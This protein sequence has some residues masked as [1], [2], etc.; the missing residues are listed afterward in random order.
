MTRFKN[1]TLGGE[2]AISYK[3]GALAL[4]VLILTIPLTSKA[5]GSS[6]SFVQWTFA[7]VVGTIPAIAALFILDRV[8]WKNRRIRP[9]KNES[10]FLAGGLIGALKGVSTELSALFLLKIDNVDLYSITERTISSSSI[11]AI[12]IPLI[13][14]M[15]FSWSANLRIR[16]T[17][18]N[19]LAGIDNLLESLGDKTVELEFLEITRD[20]ISK[21]KDEFISEFLLTSNKNKADIAY[22]LNSIA[23]ELIRP[24]SHSAN[25]ILKRSIIKDHT[26]I[27]SIHRFPASVNLGIPWLI[28]LFISSSARIQLQIRGILGGIVMLVFS[29]FIFWVCINLFVWACSRGESS[30]QKVFGNFVFAIFLNSTLSWAVSE[31]LFSDYK[32]NYLVNV[33]WCGIIVVAVGIGTLF[34]TY[35]L[36]ELDRLEVEYS[37]KYQKLLRLE[38]GRTRITASLARYLHGT[39]QTRLIASAYRIRNLSSISDDSELEKELR[40]VLSHFDLPR[41][42]TL[43]VPNKSSTQ[44]F[45]EIVELW[46][47]FMDIKYQGIALQTVPTKTMSKICEF[48]NEALSNSFRHGKA[49]AIQITLLETSKEITI[50]IQ[51]NGQIVTDIKPSLGMETF[52]WVSTHWK[53]EHLSNGT[54]VTGIFH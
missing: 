43:E 14:L 25:Q 12:S 52:N 11:G 46:K 29:T 31:M 37:A 24:L 47:S 5:E 9:V 3:I 48:L 40:I 20:R 10:L 1:I 35:E 53:L 4:P 22:K 39:M 7:A 45:E 42:F 21:A 51:D 54:L 17:K 8:I 15:S 13:A 18:L 19:E 50:K 23:I 38:Q 26:F 44:M 49:T 28:A 33:L 2:F 36:E 32:V 16:E 27:E 41:D 6:G 34:L 30:F